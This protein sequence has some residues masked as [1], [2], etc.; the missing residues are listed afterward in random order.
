VVAQGERGIQGRVLEV[1]HQGRWVEKVD[2]GD[3]NGG[4]GGETHALLEYQAMADDS[5]CGSGPA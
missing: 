1:P 2:G 3:T 4:I 5:G